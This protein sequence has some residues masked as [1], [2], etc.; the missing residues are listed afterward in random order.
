MNLLKREEKKD[1]KKSTFYRYS[2]IIGIIQEYMQKCSVFVKL[3]VFNLKNEFFD[4]YFSRI[5][6]K[7]K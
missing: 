2:Y 3:Q 6:I 1:M 7:I 4:R 5:F